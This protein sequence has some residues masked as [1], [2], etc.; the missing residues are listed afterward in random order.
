VAARLAAAT[1]AAVAAAATAAA[2][3]CGVWYH[4][5][6]VQVAVYLGGSSSTS[7]ACW[8]LMQG[9][10]L[11][12]VYAHQCQLGKGGLLFCRCGQASGLG[13]LQARAATHACAESQLAAGFARGGAA[14]YAAAVVAWMPLDGWCAAV[15]R[16]SACIHQPCTAHIF[17]FSHRAIWQRSRLH[18][19]AMPRWQKALSAWYFQQQLLQVA[20]VAAGA[21]RAWCVGCYSSVG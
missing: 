3:W 6:T 19:D 14:E 8:L 21:C 13:L 1:A 15:Q 11:H 2:A 7:T 12:C 9:V 18:V 4:S 20:H 10:G 17:V 16:S 5:C